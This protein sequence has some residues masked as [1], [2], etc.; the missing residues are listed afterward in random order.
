MLYILVDRIP[1][2][3]PDPVKWMQWFSTNGR[4]ISK[5]IIGESTIST[6]FLGISYELSPD[7]PILFETMM[8]GGELDGICL[9]CSTLDQARK[10]HADTVKK[11]RLLETRT[12]K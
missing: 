1:V 11:V 5:D 6:V 8:F 4:F 9:R 10:Q 2:E 12:M 7:G 3:E